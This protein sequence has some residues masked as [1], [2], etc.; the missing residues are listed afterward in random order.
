[1]KAGRLAQ[2]FRIFQRDNF[3]CRYCGRQSPDIRL[4]I[5]HLIPRAAGGRSNWENLVTACFECNRGKTDALL[6]VAE[7]KRFTPQRPGKTVH[8]RTRRIQHRRPNRPRQGRHITLQTNFGRSIRRDNGIPI[9]DSF[10]YVEADEF[11]TEFICS[12]CGFHNE[13]EGDGCSCRK[14]RLERERREMDYFLV[15]DCATIDLRDVQLSPLDNFER[16][17]A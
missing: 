12:E 4:E 15:E 10:V 1:M 13:Y 2:R 7:V 16:L 14:R 6:I 11:L 3:T 17:T 8:K 9:A 5:D